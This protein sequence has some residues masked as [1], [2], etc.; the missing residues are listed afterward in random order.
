[1]AQGEDKLT[2]LNLLSVLR[3][4]QPALDPAPQ[5]TNDI[6]ASTIMNELVEGV[7]R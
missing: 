1:M 4:V 7:F 2:Y 3:K 6:F 5:E